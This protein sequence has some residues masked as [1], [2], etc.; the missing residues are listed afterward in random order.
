MNAN[1]MILSIYI[2]SVIISYIIS[3]ICEYLTLKDFCKITLGDIH[4]NVIH[5]PTYQ[6]LIFIPILNI[7]Y[8]LWMFLLVIALLIVIIIYNIYIFL[9]NKFK[10]IRYIEQKCKDFKNY[11]SNIKLN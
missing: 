7:L 1:L 6:M 11:I 9:Y 4:N 8:I 10:F 2:A 3:G 5:D